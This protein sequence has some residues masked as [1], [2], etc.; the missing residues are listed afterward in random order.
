MQL[1]FQ[2]DTFTACLECHLV[3]DKVITSINIIKGELGSDIHD[4][5]QIQEALALSK[6]RVSSK[7][8]ETQ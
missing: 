6:E 7:D 4:N 3:S 8:G 5:M 2:T 1:S